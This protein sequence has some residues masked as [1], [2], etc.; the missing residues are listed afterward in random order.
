[1]PIWGIFYFLWD[2]PLFTNIVGDPKDY[3]NDPD[4]IELRR[5][6]R[7]E[8]LDWLYA[9]IEILQQQ[10]AR[11][12]AYRLEAEARELWTAKQF[13]KVVPPDEAQRILIDRRVNNMDPDFSFE[14]AL[15]K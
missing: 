1:M 10:L 11:E 8:L 3:V 5:T 7:L 15:T 2:D 9:K 14:A 13:L 4:F 6:M 12:K